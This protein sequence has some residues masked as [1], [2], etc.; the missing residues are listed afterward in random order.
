MSAATFEA[1]KSECLGVDGEGLGNPILVGGVVVVPPRL[2]LLQFDKVRPIPVHLVR[3]HV[4]EGAF[5]AG[6]PGGLEQVER[7]HR[8]NVEII[9]GPGGGEIVAG[10]GSGVD[11]GGGLELGDEMQNFFSVTNVELVVLEV[12]IVLLQPLLIPAGVAARTE[13][14]RPLVVVDTVHLRP[15]PGEIAHNFGADQAGGAGN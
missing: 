3:R 8:V 15:L 2:Q 10:L 13:E 12:L 4:G 14:I 9:K 5:R 7:A 11:D 6:P 1:P